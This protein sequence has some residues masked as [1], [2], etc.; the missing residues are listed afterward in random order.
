MLVVVPAGDVVV[1]VA[2]SSGRA[3]VDGGTD[4]GG[5]VVVTV[6]DVVVGAAVEVAVRGGAV[7]VV[8]DS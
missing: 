7:E 1:V 2:P 6:V 4:V 5:M 3:T 8:V